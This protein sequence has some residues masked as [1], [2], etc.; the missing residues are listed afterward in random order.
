M[1][2][3][4][5]IPFGTTILD[6]YTLGVVA[7]LLNAHNDVTAVM[8]LQGERRRLFDVGYAQSADHELADVA[9]ELKLLCGRNREAFEKLIR[10]RCRDRVAALAD[11]C[12][13]D[14]H[15]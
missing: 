3:A 7:G 4:K 15:E 14:W 13:E 8:V 11:I 2:E 5:S 9:P 6:P 12:E 1:R 10:L